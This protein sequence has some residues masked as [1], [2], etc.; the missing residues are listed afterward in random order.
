MTLLTFIFRGIKEDGDNIINS[1]SHTAP[2]NNKEDMDSETRFETPVIKIGYLLSFIC[3]GIGGGITLFS[4]ISGVTYLVLRSKRKKRAESHPSL[5]P[6]NE[7]LPCPQNSQNSTLAY[8]SKTSVNKSLVYSRL[9]KSDFIKE[10]GD[11]APTQVYDTD[12]LSI[13]PFLTKKFKGPIVPSDPKAA[14]T[15]L[16]EALQEPLIKDR[17]RKLLQA[18]YVFQ[19]HFT[20]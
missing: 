10:E 1:D 11:G 8:P 13:V 19:I 2:K 15:L 4:L 20:H 18:V 3:G 16:R 7:S 17:A 14:D 6:F 12:N 5:E 9:R